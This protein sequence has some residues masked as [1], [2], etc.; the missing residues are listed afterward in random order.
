MGVGGMLS[1]FTNEK[2]FCLMDAIEGVNFQY[3][4]KMG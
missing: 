1:W 2:E 3:L 4:E